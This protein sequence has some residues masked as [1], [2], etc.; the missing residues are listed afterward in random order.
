MSKNKNPALALHP[1]LEATDEELVVTDGAS[2][3]AA[4]TVATAQQAGST[5]APDRRH[6]LGVLLMGLGI[7]AL[8]VAW[9][10]VSGTADTVDQ[11]SY[12]GTGVTLG[13]CLMGAGTVLLVACE[14][15]RDREAIHELAAQLRRLEEGLAGEFDHLETAIRA[16]QT[17]RRV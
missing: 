14:H 7:V 2:A 8:L 6:S 16:D 13:L 5:P 4:P 3:R 11:L 1:L 17:L 9:W 12:I 10:G 15:G